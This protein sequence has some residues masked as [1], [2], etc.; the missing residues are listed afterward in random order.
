MMKKEKEDLLRKQRKFYSKDGDYL[1]MLNVYY[2]LREFMSNTPS[3]NAIFW[4]KENGINKRAFVNRSGGKDWDLI[5][6]KARR[7][8]D[9]LEKIVKPPELR[10]KFYNQYKKDGAI[11]S[12]TEINK[13]IK[14]IKNMVIDPDDDIL[15]A[16]LPINNKIIQTGG[17]LAKE[18]ELN[19]FPNAE[20]SNSRQNNILM[21]LALGN[22]TNIAVLQDKKG[23]YKTCFPQEKVYC[24]GDMGS[25]LKSNPQHLI[26]HELFTMRKDQKILKLNLTTNVPTSI[27]N[28]LKKTYSEFIKTCF[29][30][31]TGKIDYGYSDKKSWKKSDKKFGKKYDKK[32]GKKYNKKY[33]KKV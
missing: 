3:G 21:A 32:F 11:E 23:T 8:N 29:E 26:Y 25:S 20:K 6:D 14:Q 16:D 33:T 28:N 13:E 15:N 17:Y 1:T 10:K 7:I 22:I 4:C 31:P 24:K 2:A 27:I 18:Y 5:G 9:T 19:L 30:K 12:I